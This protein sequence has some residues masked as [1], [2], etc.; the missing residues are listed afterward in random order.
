MRKLI[1]VSPLL[2]CIVCFCPR[3]CFAQSDE[4]SI[5]ATAI[6]SLPEVGPAQ[7]DFP[8][9]QRQ[10]AYSG[11]DNSGLS[12]L[13]IG[14]Q[15]STLGPGAELAYEVTRRLNVRGGFNYF[16]Y[17]TN[18]TNDGVTYDGGL[19]LESGEA[20]VDVF[21][22]RSL[23]VS[24]GVLY[25][26]NGSLLNATLSVPAGQSFTLSGTTYTSNGLAGTGALKFNRVA[27]SVLLGIGNLVPR[28]RHHFSMKF[29]V[30]GAFRGSPAVA[31]NFTGIV[32]NQTDTICQN[33]ATSP[34]FQSSVAAQQA[35]FDSDISYF[36]FYPI[37]SV[38]FGFKL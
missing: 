33:A 27:P 32:C 5:P 12:R 15:I 4:G 14:I 28:G 6:S 19:K 16:S 24:P 9:A 13:G 30:G 10:A 11:A 25:S 31:L 21:L 2:L 36:K 35:K 1:L 7:P 17:T 29:E 38:G 22:W 37:V 3:S 20:S 23:H 8:P 34:Q 18:F 26:P